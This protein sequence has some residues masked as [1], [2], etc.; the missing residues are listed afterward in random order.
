[1]LAEEG[2]Q[3]SLLKVNWNITRSRGVCRRESPFL[4]EEVKT[5]LLKGITIELHLSRWMKW[6][7]L[8]RWGH[9]EKL[10]HNPW[11]MAVPWKTIV[12]VVQSLSCVGVFATSETAA[13]QA[14]LSF[15]VFWSLL[16]FMSIEPGMPSNHLILF[17][18]DWERKVKT[19]KAGR[20]HIM[21]A[22]KVWLRI[23]NSNLEGKKSIWGCGRKIYCNCQCTFSMYL[24]SV[25][26][27]CA[28]VLSHFSRV[29][30]SMTPWTKACQ[31][32]LSI[33]FS[34]QEHWSRLPF[35][36]PLCESEKWKW[37]RSVVSDSL[38]PHGL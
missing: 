36:S 37:S 8:G 1:M 17:C 26:K 18:R 7:F 23:L 20:I 24:P 31:A 14:S 21:E 29:Q 22:L 11:I 38:R 6:C 27:V 3:S 2:I 34:R 16:R 12:I 13:C 19:R 33:G 35:P 5:S 30:L 32:P 10:E 25:R 4:S 15:T 9:R 28:C